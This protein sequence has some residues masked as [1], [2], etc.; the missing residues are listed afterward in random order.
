MYKLFNLCT[1]FL[2]FLTRVFHTDYKRISV[3]V[4]IYAQGFV[5]F[6]AAA[7]AFVVTLVRGND[8]GLTAVSMI[9]LLMAL[10]QMV[11]VIWAC[12]RYR[13]PLGEAFERCYLDLVGLSSKTH[14]P[15]TVLNIFIFVV[16]YLLFLV[17]DVF[18]IL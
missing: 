9:W 16:I 4:N 12:L 7:L 13:P 5:M 18:L 8:D 10:A 2:V 14:L 17:L 15:Y 1:N 11:I 3:W 6:V